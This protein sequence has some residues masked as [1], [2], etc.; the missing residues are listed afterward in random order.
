MGFLHALVASL[1]LGALI[2]MI[3]QWADQEESGKA[4]GEAA[5]L[6]TFALWGLLGCLAAYMGELIAPAVYAVTLAALAGFLGV[7]AVV[8][9]GS[10]S[11]PG[12]TGYGLALLTFFTGTLVYL[13]RFDAALLL[14]AAMIVVVAAKPFTHAW[15]RKL[16][17][18]DIYLVTQFAVVSGIILPL[19]PN[20]GYGP[21]QAF[22]PYNIWLMVVLIS[23]LGFVGYIA[24]RLLGSQAGITVTGFAGGLASSTATT[25]ALTRNSRADPAMSPVLAQGIVI[26][27]TVVLGRV[28]L[29]VLALSP[30]LF[31]ALAVPFIVMA[32]PAVCWVAWVMWGRRHNR[33]EAVDTPAVKNPL[34]LKMAI[35]F[36]LLYGFIVFL[37]KATASLGHAGFYP[38]AFLSGLTDMDAITLSLTHT[39]REGDMLVGLAAQGIV[40]AAVAN[41][42]FKTG[43]A[44]ALGAPGFRRSVATGMIPMLVAGIPAWFLVGILGG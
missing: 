23:G 42:L 33:Q 27:N 7:T 11:S 30:A 29:I 18:E 4:G 8:W 22:N 3:R 10:P 32:L 21:L 16:T 2:G 44:L 35:K 15:T 9:K 20:Q 6:R 12:M 13:G 1:S 31:S 26:A 38:V 17:R 41:T 37:V 28:L 14:T 39:V 5:G 43:F 40:V 24:M 25:F 36:A 19:V 34:S